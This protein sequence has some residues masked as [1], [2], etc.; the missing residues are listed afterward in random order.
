MQEFCSQRQVERF[1]KRRLLCFEISATFF[2]SFSYFL[3]Q[4]KLYGKLNKF[5]LYCGGILKLYGSASIVFP[6]RKCIDNNS[7]QRD[8]LSMS[9]SGCLSLCVPEFSNGNFSN[10]FQQNKMSIKGNG[11][12]PIYL[13]LILIDCQIKLSLNIMDLM[14]F[15][16]FPENDFKRSVENFH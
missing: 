9:H 5:S 14:T 16:S 11:N 10:N 1:L 8:R 7:F 2:L 4:A 3:K 6:G 12:V 13:I 15:N